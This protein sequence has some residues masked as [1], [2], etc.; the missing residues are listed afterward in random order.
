[1]RKRRLYK[2][3]RVP[4]VTLMVVGTI[5]LISIAIPTQQSCRHPAW[6]KTVLRQNVEWPDRAGTPRKKLIRAFGA[7][8]SRYA[9]ERS[10]L[11]Y[12]EQGGDAALYELR[13]LIDQHVLASAG[14]GAAPVFDAANGVLANSPYEYLNRD[15]ALA[16]LPARMIILAEK[17]RLFE[18]GIWVLCADGAVAYMPLVSGQETGERLYVGQELPPQTSQAIDGN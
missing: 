10:R 1:M 13:S 8:I 11:P 17:P 3:I 15:V 2:A 14:I 4:L 5:L 12:S 18:N 16:D 6:L 9:N 7:A